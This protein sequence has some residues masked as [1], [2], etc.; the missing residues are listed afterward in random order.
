MQEPPMPVPQFST[1]Q[2]NDYAAVLAAYDDIFGDGPTG[3][4]NR[5]FTNWLAGCELMPTE[6]ARALEHLRNVDAFATLYGEPKTSEN[7]DQLLAAY[8]MDRSALGR[9]DAIAADPGVPF[10]PLYQPKV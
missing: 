9:P 8:G 7:L 10:E 5:A 6:P 4:L 1:T 2:T 3:D